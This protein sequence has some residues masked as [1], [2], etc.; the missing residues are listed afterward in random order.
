VR[1]RY[2]V[3]AHDGAASDAAIG[4]WHAAFLAGK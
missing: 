1:A 3:I 2:R 4:A